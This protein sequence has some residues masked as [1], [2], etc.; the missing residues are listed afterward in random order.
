MKTK[1]E[2]SQQLYVVLFILFPERLQFW[3]QFEIQKN[4]FAV[5]VFDWFYEKLFIHSS[6]ERN[7]K[8]FNFKSWISFLL[9]ENWELNAKLNVNSRWC[10]SRI[11]L[12]KMKPSWVIPF[13]GIVVFEIWMSNLPQWKRWNITLIPRLMKF[14]FEQNIS[15]VKMCF[16]RRESLH[17]KHIHS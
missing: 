6:Q 10:E 12:F 9:F 15:K 16:C 4:N 2:K 13:S 14:P 5:Y 17:T 3:Y 11:Q 8:L 1:V 7:I